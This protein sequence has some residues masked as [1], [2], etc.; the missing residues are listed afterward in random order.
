MEL[1]WSDFNV[2]GLAASDTLFTLVFSLL[3]S[4]VLYKLIVFEG[5]FD[6]EGQDIWKTINR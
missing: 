4:G 3:A 5:V 1:L 2:F 6:C